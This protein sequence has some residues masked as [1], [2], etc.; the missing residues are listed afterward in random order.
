MD[1]P[2]SPSGRGSREFTSRLRGLTVAMRQKRR[3]ALLAIKKEA[4]IEVARKYLKDKADN[5]AVAVISAEERL[6]K[7][8]NGPER[9][10]LRIE[11]I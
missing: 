10:N 9:L 3:E 5:S 11:K 8:N 6:R 7:A 4:L 1:R 2:L